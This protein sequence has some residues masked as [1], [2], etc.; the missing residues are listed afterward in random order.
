[1]LSRR[2]LPAASSPIAH[3]REVSVSRQMRTKWRLASS[4]QP[5]A[6]D[7]PRSPYANGKALDPAPAGRRD[8]RVVD[9]PG[10]GIF[11]SP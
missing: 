10:R 1:M 2:Q 3:A 9:Q 7:A 11:V 8:V 4:A 5:A 6:F